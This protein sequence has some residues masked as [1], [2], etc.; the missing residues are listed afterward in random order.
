MTRFEMLEHL[1]G[2]QLVANNTSFF[3]GV[4]FTHVP[5]K[6]GGPGEGGAARIARHFGVRRLVL[7]QIVDRGEYLLACVTWMTFMFCLV[8]ADSFRILEQFPAQA[9]RKFA[10]V[11]CFFVLLHGLLTGKQLA[12]SAARI[13]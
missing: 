13:S 10:L 3:L 4:D 2:N 9:A 5:L 6:V 7:F 1:S 11:V 12:A 8:N